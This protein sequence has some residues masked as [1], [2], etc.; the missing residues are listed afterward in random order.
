MR[1][2]I[3][4]VESLECVKSEDCEAAW[5]LWRRLP[6][7]KTRRIWPQ[8]CTHARRP[9]DIYIYIYIYIYI[10]RQ[11]RAGPQRTQGAPSITFVYIHMHITSGSRIRDSTTVV[12]SLSVRP[13]RQSTPGFWFLWF[14]G[15]WLLV[16]L[17]LVKLYL[18]ISRYV[19]RYLCSQVR[20]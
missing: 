15:V 20:T 7:S 11:R 1:F 12:S 2:R 8:M 4:A 9:T 3:S 10:I 18:W 14:H 19:S 17:L 5:R 16:R 6:G 13:A